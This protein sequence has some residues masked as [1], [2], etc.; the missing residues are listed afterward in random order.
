MF[1]GTECGMRREEKIEN[2]LNKN[3]L[4]IILI[5]KVFRIKNIF[6]DLSE[7]GSG[8]NKFEQ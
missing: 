1:V 4:K 6:V 3:L 7:R 8:G 2:T 5:G